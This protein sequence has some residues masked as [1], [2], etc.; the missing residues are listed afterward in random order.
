[1]SILFDSNFDCVESI[2]DDT[3]LTDI[4]LKE[5]DKRLKKIS[6][7]EFTEEELEILKQCEIDVDTAFNSDD[8]S[9]FSSDDI[10]EVSNNIKCK[11]I[12]N[13]AL[14][15]ISEC[16][17]KKCANLSTS[18]LETGKSKEI[19]NTALIAI[20]EC[21]E[22]KAK[23][24]SKKS[25][26]SIFASDFIPKRQDKP[27]KIILKGFIL[28]AYT[29]SIVSAGYIVK[30]FWESFEAKQDQKSIQM[31]HNEAIQSEPVLNTQP[32]K[33]ESEL[34]AP[35]PV[36]ALTATAK[37]LLA[38]NEDTV[39]YIRIPDTG[40]D[41]VVVQGEDNEYYLEHNVYNES[42]QC[43]TLFVDFRCAI[44]QQNSQNIIIYGHNQYDG[45]MFG[46]LDFY[47]WNLDYWKKNPIIYFDTNYES[48]AYVIVAS[49]V[50]NAVPED[51][52][53]SIFD[54]QNYIY[55]NDEF[56]FS[57]WYNEV[58]TRTEF[59]T[60]IDF[61][62]N[63]SY[64]TLSTCSTEWEPSRHVIIARKLRAEESA[65]NIDTSGWWENPNPKYPQK[66]YDL[67]GGGVWEPTS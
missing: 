44:G 22:K 32:E 45:T 49:F 43:G 56:P 51:D 25:L 41:G 17:E 27:L 42:R 48:D 52:N 40:V 66:Y 20:A 33:A 9:I 58:I 65:D 19:S 8:F 61:Q 10:M 67:Y 4:E 55:F 28:V 16:K 1:M 5:L 39:G 14:L 53:N 59:Y 64:I 34:I 15:A 11:D 29:V 63:D 50:T 36:L 3:V 37:E 60:N 13:T 18:A 62:A 6:T 46:D 54:Y 47:R 38:I 12:S 7:I 2:F 24:N 30:Y 31:V 21:K 26:F 57:E 23:G 35:K